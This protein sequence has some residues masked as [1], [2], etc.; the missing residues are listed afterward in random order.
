MPFTGVPA[1]RQTQWNLENLKGAIALGGQAVKSLELVNGGAAIGLLTF[2]G[3]A[4]AKN[5][6]TSIDVWWLKLALVSF[7]MGVALAVLTSILAYISQLI[8]A[9]ENPSDAEVNWRLGALTAGISSAITFVLGVIFV[10][11]A[12]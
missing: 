9:T 1:N 8:S 4:A 12:F 10:A 6:Q 11:V 3:N 5:P 7:A 2:Y